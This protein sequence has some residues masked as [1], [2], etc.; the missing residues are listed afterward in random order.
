MRTV[1]SEQCSNEEAIAGELLLVIYSST[2][3][4]EL[5]SRKKSFGQFQKSREIEDTLNRSKQGFTYA[6]YQSHRNRVFTTPL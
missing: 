5:S 4:L 2:V 6:S 1:V 3:L